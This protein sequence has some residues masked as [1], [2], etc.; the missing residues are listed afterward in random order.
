MKKVGAILVILTLF[1]G[2][3]E[4]H[5]DRVLHVEADG[6]I[7]DIPAAFGQARL[8]LEGLGSEKPLVRLKIGASQTTLPF[9][10]SRMIRSRDVAQIRVSG[11]WYH[12]ETRSLPYY[13]GIQFFDPGYDPK[14]H[15]NSGQEFLFNLHDAKLIHAKAFEANQSG[16]GGQS[17]EL[18]LPADCQLNTNS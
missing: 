16:N 12:D 17:K 5:R 10:V 2:A 9:C 8:T 15:Y 18:N 1:A 4:A 14:R 13:L 3:A 7:S 11:S 6:S